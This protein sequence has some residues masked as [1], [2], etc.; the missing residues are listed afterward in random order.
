MHFRIACIYNYIYIVK[1]KKLGIICKRF[2]A[3]V[4]LLSNL[5]A[6]LIRV[7]YVFYVIKNVIVT[8]VIFAVYVLS[9]SSLTD[10]RKIEF[11]HFY[12]RSSD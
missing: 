6:V 4:N 1:G 7:Y 11:F 12:L 5:S 3:G 9:A 2:A 10:N 8:A